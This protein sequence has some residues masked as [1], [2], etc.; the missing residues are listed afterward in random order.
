MKATTA[1][2]NKKACKKSVQNGCK[3]SHYRM[4]AGSVLALTFSARLDGMKNNYM[5]NFIPARR[6]SPLATSEISAKRASPVHV[7]GPYG[8]NNC[9]KAKSFIFLLLNKSNSQKQR[10]SPP[11][12]ADL[13]AWSHSVRKAN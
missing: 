5:G 3:T 11:K 8:S 4:Y 10:F 2:P 1:Y 13:K 12:M 9:L 6:A 7:I